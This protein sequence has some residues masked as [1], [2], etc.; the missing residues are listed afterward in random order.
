MIAENLFIAKYDSS[1]FFFPQPFLNIYS[2]FG[3]GVYRGTMLNYENFYNIVLNSKNNAPVAN[4]KLP[5]SFKRAP[6]RL[7]VKLRTRHEAFLNRYPHFLLPF[8]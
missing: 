2:F 8:A 7:A 5:I 3:R 1:I 4:P 6:Q